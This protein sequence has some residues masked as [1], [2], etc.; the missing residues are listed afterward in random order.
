MVRLIEDG[1]GALRVI[2]FLFLWAIFWSS[3][4]VLKLHDEIT[5]LQVL[6]QMF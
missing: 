5:E 6:I 3:I 2:F 4:G 1:Y